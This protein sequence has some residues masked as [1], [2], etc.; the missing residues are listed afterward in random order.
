MNPKYDAIKDIKHHYSQNHRSMPRNNRA[1]QF[2]P[3]SALNGYNEAIQE[4]GR[5]VDKKKE[6]TEQE[7]EIL[8]SHLSYIFDMKIKDE[9]YIV[10]F[11]KDSNKDGGKYESIISSIRRIDDVNRKIILSNKKIIDIDDIY[12]ISGDAFK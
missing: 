3:F 2:A 1:A 11:V 5:E 4:V 6:L 7:K 12:S 10:Y 9:V 8:S